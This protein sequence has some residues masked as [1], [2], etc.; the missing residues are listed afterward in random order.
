MFAGRRVYALDGVCCKTPDTPDNQAAFG[1][2]GAS[3]GRA[4]HPQLRMAWLADAGTRLVRAVRFGSYR[5]GEADLARRLL[6]DLP[7]GALLLWDR[8]LFAGDLL[9]DAAGGPAA[10]ALLVRIGKRI[11]TRRLR[12]LGKGDWLVEIEL[13]HACRRGR[14]DLPRTWT[15]REIVFRPKGSKEETRLLTTLTD[16]DQA[17]AAGLADLY[18]ERWEIETVGDEFKTHLCR[19]ATVNR[20]VVFRSRTAERVRQELYGL[21]IAY[22]AVRRT[23]ARAAAEAA[24]PAPDPTR[25]AEPAQ[26]EARPAEPK[27]PQARQGRGQARAGRPDPRDPLRLSFTSAAE[28]LR[29]A[30]WDMMRMDVRRLPERHRLML[31]AIAR[32]TVPKR[33][34]RRNPREVK[35]KMSNYPRKRCA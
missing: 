35:I 3:R 31:A 9:W 18:R 29:E 23:M 1:R 5:T 25:P 28:R 34:E 15:L 17:P 10:A 21:L 33:P 4:G 27:R 8:G 11:R 2:P 6:A 13:S 24:A 7:A 32:A 14:P 22:N 20:P 30:A 26:G 12:R 16:P 19:C